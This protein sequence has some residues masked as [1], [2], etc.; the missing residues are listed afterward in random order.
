MASIVKLP[1]GNWRALV[2]LAGSKP[3]SATFPKKSE[4]VAWAKLVESKYKHI[5]YNGAAPVPP[6]S[7]FGDFI[8]LYSSEVGTQKEFGRSKKATLKRLKE[9]LGSVRM[10]HFSEQTL[11]EFSRRRMK[12]GAGGVTISADLSYISGILRWIKGAKGYDV[13]T[14]VAKNMRANL[15]LMGL[16]TRGKERER[17][18]TEDEIDRIIAGYAPKKKQ[19]IDMPTVIRFALATSMR[20][21][22]ITSIKIED[23]DIESRTVII[24]DRKDPKEKIGNDQVVPLLPDA[25]SIVKKRVGDR[26][27]G[28]IFGYDSRSIS[29]SF[30]RITAELGID[31]LRFHDLRHTAITKLFRLGLTIERVAI[32]SGHKDWKTL[33]RYTHLNANDV[34]MEFERLLAQST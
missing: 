31:D 3:Q 29:A 26:K 22:E 20:L 11:R 9:D 28:R 17:I 18:A 21:S 16:S 24:R 27:S 34:H 2:R 6:R 33:K 30:T 1:S 15:P 32:M 10:E 23:L 12:S 14:N 5:R 19:Q 8:D 7:T 13:D 4:A 25:M